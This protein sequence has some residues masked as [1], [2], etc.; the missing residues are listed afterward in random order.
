MAICKGE[1]AAMKNV[2]QARNYF[3]AS[4][5]ATWDLQ[6]A[7]NQNSR[8]INEG[9]GFR[10]AALVCALTPAQLLPS[11]PLETLTLT[12]RDFHFQGFRGQ[13]LVSCSKHSCH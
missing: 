4:L 13:P 9:G 5:S 12:L 11:F 6:H 10:G 8:P 2:L 3:V 1:Q 7:P